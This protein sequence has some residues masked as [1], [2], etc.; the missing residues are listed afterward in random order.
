MNFRRSI[1]LSAVALFLTVAPCFAGP[2]AKEIAE[3]Q[4]AFDAKLDA[5][6]ASGPTAP[7][8][9][10]ATLHHQPT[11]STVAHAEA[12]LRDI[13][14]ENAE[15]VTRALERAQDADLIGDVSRA[16]K[17]NSPRPRKRCTSRASARKP[18]RNRA[19]ATP[20]GVRLLGGAISMQSRRPEA[21]QFWIS[22]WRSKRLKTQ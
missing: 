13:S 17:S 2:C 20:Q 8:S 9:T 14:R 15:I 21:T 10:L 18:D 22:R 6:A 16:A 19:A 1:P 5:A 4:A 11:P 7:E 12:Q 3:A